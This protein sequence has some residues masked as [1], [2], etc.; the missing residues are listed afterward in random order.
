MLQVQHNVHKANE[1]TEAQKETAQGLDRSTS[2]ENTS[3][4]FLD[5]ILYLTMSGV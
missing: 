5:T 3:D 2:F 4:N 1:S